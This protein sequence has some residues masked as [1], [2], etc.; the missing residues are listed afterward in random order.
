MKKLTAVLLALVMVLSMAV[1][2]LA[3]DPRNIT[4]G[5]WWDIYYDSNDESWE[6]NEAATGKD[7]DLMRFDNVKNIEDTYGVTYEFQNLTYAGVQ[8]SVNNS[9]LA[10]EPDCDVYMVE[11]GWG[12]P[13]VMNG[14]AMDL[15]DVLDPDDPLLTHNDT[16]MNYVALESGAVSLLTVNG[17]EDQVAATYP[18]A[19]NLQ[20]IE[21]A[22]LEDPRELAARGEWTWDKFR[23]YCIAL[24]KDNDGDG[25]TDVYGYGAWITDCLPYWYM[26]NGTT[27]AS[28]PKENLSSV[29]MGETLKFLQDLWLTDKAA[30]PL[31][32]EN[33]WD[34]CRWLYRDKKVAFTTTAAWIMANY[35]DYNWDGKAETT[36]DFDM[37]FVDYPIGPHGNAE[38]NATKIA[39]GS[40]YFIPVGIENPKLVYDVFRAYQNW[41]HDDTALRD[42][43]EELEWWYTT[44][45]DKL[46]L[47]EWNFEIMKKMG[48]KT[49]V[50]FAGTVLEQMPLVEFINGDLTPA[51]LQEEY[52]QVVQD[53]LDQIFGA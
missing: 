15:R 13:A 7:S 27:L 23:E 36:L 4:I 16:V 12:V 11:L 30:Y 32:E 22:N 19:F 18:L 39:A 37:V 1:T 6:D 26:S 8:D 5:L 43:P 46:D 9:I 44:T 40:F 28:T 14:Y 2:A 52:K 34:V 48:E 51:Q 45:S 24:T 50:D 20:M 53:T 33:G 25:V 35:D 3:E 21:E 29:E 47:Q 10:G 38:T 41:Y 49:V 42:D 31:P 17:A